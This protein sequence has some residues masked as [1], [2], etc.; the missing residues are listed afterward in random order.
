LGTSAD[1]ALFT[2]VGAVTNAGTEY[3][4]QITGNVG[5][6]S[7][8]ISGF[9]NVDGQLH[10]G[11][12]QSA[13]AAADLLIAYGELAAAIPTFFPAPLLGNG[14]I[15]PPGVYAIA[16]PATLNLDLTLDAQNDPTAV[17]IFQI[18]GSFGVNANSKVH[19]IN[20]AQACNV[21][22]KVE[23][24]VSLAEN[25]TMR[26]TIVAN[27]AAI[28]MT[29]GDTL[30]GRALSIN[31]AIGVTQS[32]IYT[33]S[34]CGAPILTGPAAPVLSSIEC[35]TIFSS[36]GPVTN[37]GITN[38]TG[39]VG[40]NNGL[41]TGFN[42][43]F[44]TGTIHPIP[45][46]STAQAASDLLDVYTT[47]NILPYDIILMRP[48]ML[49]HNL[50]LT[51]HTYVMNAAASL[52]DSLYLN[53]QG[54][55]DAVFIIKIY[56]AL[57]TSN[58]SKVIL[59]NGTQSKNVFWLV[60]GS[61]NITDFS[62][63][64][65]TIIVNNGAIDLT[66]GVNLDGRALTT[67]G[68]IN[69]S[70]ITAIMPPGCAS[71]NPPVITTE[72]TAQIVCE[73]DPV[74]FSVTATGDGLTYQWRRGTTDL[75]DGSIISGA[76]TSTLTIDP[77]S[78]SDAA[79]DYNV[80]VSGTTP[81]VANSI[82][83]SLTVNPYTGPTIFTMGATTLCQDAPD[84]TYTAT[85]VN[86]TSITYSVLP[87]TAGVI[88]LTTGVMNWDAIF[89]GSATITATSTGICDSTSADL[90]V[91]INPLPLAITGD[92]STICEGDSIT[93]GTSPLTGHIYLWTP[94][95]GLS[96]T[97]IANP[98]ASPTATTTYTLTESINGTCDSTNSVT[99]TVNY[100][101]EI[102]IQP[103]DHAGCEGS[104]ISFVVT[105]TGTDI[106]FQW[107]KG[108]VNLINGGSISGVTTHVLTINPVNISHVDS[109]YN[110][111]ITGICS[112]DLISDYVTL[113]LNT[114]PTIVSQPVD[115]AVCVGDAADF[116]VTATGTEITYQWKK[117]TVN[118]IDGGNISGATSA[119]LTINPVNLSDAGSDYHVVL[120]GS[121]S[122]DVTSIDVS[123]EAY[124]AAS[125][126]TEPVD[127][128]ACIGESASFSVD[129]IG[130]ELTFQWRKGITNLIDGGNI[131]GANSATLTINPVENDDLDTNYN[132]IVSGICSITVT[133][134]D[135]SL[136]MCTTTSI[137]TQDDA[138][139][140]TIYPNPFHNSLNVVIN[141]SPLFNMV[142][143]NIYNVLGVEV[144]H[145]TLTE[146][147]N[148]LDTSKL[149]KGVYLYRVVIDNEII[150][151]GILI[152]EQ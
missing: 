127:T 45:D 68:A 25:T 95:T 49:G 14:A 111:V 57:S 152:S 9:G 119:T 58:Y 70:A 54:N 62:E 99:I 36:D 50:V 125:I 121:C 98:V 103:I 39:D 74:S 6:N 63:F 23:G 120:S 146:K 151:S 59:L 90:L 101:P 34:G 132:V 137:D 93:L 35:Y 40:S 24:L 87:I 82:D 141:F 97:T 41:T 5:T 139:V 80:V 44:V 116:S 117:G 140:A 66:T 17:F 55:A 43:L 1:F 65:G 113:I 77:V 124:S 115:Q 69:T 108:T 150:Q 122:G 104:I 149:P 46:G 26:G 30:E 79:I 18:Q 12:P 107:R 75:I 53:A 138:R 130:S 33:P 86:S 85:A 143:L 19:L 89:N 37:A 21:F 2:T 15:L 76:T 110:V 96:S 47:M 145:K 148:I 88:N 102:I 118:L 144:I 38:V 114:P 7:G 32:N 123:L 106:S 105:A 78:I 13:Q 112:P 128:I 84:E 31:G 109:N 42:P 61:V 142:Y 28:N 48:D 51:P 129:A 67:V 8:P 11:D 136:S 131:S 4:T 71:A 27:N 92:D 22:W 29:A 135:V 126:I 134:A 72:P 16:E 73:G 94:A 81:P 100:A 10:P 52:T 133:S 64:V 83:V 91:T 3:L 147:S 60:A 56:G 20:G